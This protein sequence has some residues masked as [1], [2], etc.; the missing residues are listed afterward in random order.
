MLTR[1]GGGHSRFYHFTE[2]FFTGMENGYSRMLGAF[3]K[4][5]WTA[6]IIIVACIASAYVVGSNL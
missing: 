1:S 4:V 2:P 5:R 6:L 3:M